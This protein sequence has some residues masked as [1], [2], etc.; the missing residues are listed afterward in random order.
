VRGSEEFGPYVVYEQIG[1]GGMAT[2]HRAETQ[3]IAGFSKQVALKRM[4]PNVADD[5]SLVKSFIREARLASHLRHAN[6][7]QTYDL[8]KVG[9]TYFIA[10]ELVPGRNLREILK[11]CAMV[12]GHMPV[13]IAMNIVNQIGDALDYAHNLCDETGQPLGIIHRD[14]SPAN[15][16]VSE[17]GVVKLIDFGIAKASGGGMQ[18][19][20]GTIKG[21]F[22]YLAPECLSGFVDARS[23][24]FALGVIAYELLTNRP[25]LQGKDDMDTLHRVKH[26]PIIPVSQVNPRVP[27]EIESIIMTALERD[28]EERWQ[29]ATAMRQALTTETQRLGLIAHNAEV[30]AWI[31]QAFRKQFHEESEPS[32]VISRNTMEL[33]Q[34]TASEFLD[35]ADDVETIIKPGG[36]QQLQAQQQKWRAETDLPT[37]DG[38][39]SLGEETLTDQQPVFDRPTSMDPPSQQLLAQAA[40]DWNSSSVVETVHDRPRL[41]DWNNASSAQTREVKQGRRSSSPHVIQRGS[42]SNPALRI[43]PDPRDSSPTLTQQRAERGSQ[44]PASKRPSSPPP[45][46][47]TLL[48]A[49]APVIPPSGARSAQQAAHPP[50]SDV[51][52]SGSRTA[53]VLVLDSDAA[54]TD[55]SVTASAIIHEEDVGAVLADLDQRSSVSTPPKQTKRSASGS[56]LLAVLVLIAAGG[57]AAVVY[58]ALPYLT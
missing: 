4:L 45:V 37:L 36:S 33:A 50:P 26:M 55:V 49:A 3:G 40:S 48:N 27:F 18:T 23:D 47:R 52:L 17:G 7:A 58:F 29:R 57:A 1:I 15:V 54:K 19:L 34:G 9:D 8:G 46:Q 2:V 42:G 10:M 5:A 13:P 22:S 53:P 31:D 25:L 43:D 20:S 28:P 12:A 16:I 6:V 14:V 38:K 39:Q 56:F 32:I 21:K 51:P 24:L 35:H 41:A 11:H 30:E 44:P